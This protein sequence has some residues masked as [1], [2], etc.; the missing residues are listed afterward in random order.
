MYFN[1]K[2]CS[3]TDILLLP[4]LF[5]NYR[6]HRG[7]EK[8]NLYGYM[9]YNY[10]YLNDALKELDLGLDKSQLTYLRNKNSRRFVS[11]L[12]NHFKKNKKISSLKDLWIKADFSLQSLLSGIFH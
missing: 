2:A 1:L 10:R 8:N 3:Q 9:H 11:N 12:F 4:K 6:I 7:Q 5:L